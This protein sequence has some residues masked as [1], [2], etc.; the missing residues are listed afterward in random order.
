MSK[1]HGNWPSRMVRGLLTSALLLAPAASL[2]DTF[3]GGIKETV[4]C[5]GAGI[6]YMFDDF[7]LDIE[8]G[9]SVGW[10][11][12]L[13]GGFEVVTDWMVDGKWGYFA[14]TL[15]DADFGPVTLYG[16]IRGG[17]MKGWVVQHDYS[18]S[19]ILYGKLKAWR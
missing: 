19:C 18:T 2:A 3:S 14:A 17:K 9:A 5:P 15:Q 13:G 12:I 1:R 7:S 16:W 11:T 4:V 6:Q 8:Q 10:V